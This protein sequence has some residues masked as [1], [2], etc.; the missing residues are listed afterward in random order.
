MSPGCASGRDLPALRARRLRGLRPLRHPVR[1]RRSASEARSE[2]LLGRLAD[3]ALRRC[4]QPHQV[5]DPRPVDAGAGRVE[6]DVAVAVLGEQDRVSESARGAHRADVGV[7]NSVVGGSG[8]ALLIGATA[9]PSSGLAVAC[10]ALAAGALTLAQLAHE[11]RTFTR[12]FEGLDVAFPS[13]NDPPAELEQRPRRLIIQTRYRLPYTFLPCKR[14]RPAGGG[15]SLRRQGPLP[16][17]TAPPAS[18]CPSASP[19]RRGGRGEASH[20]RPV[21]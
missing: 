10:G 21:I 18:G 3:G 14:A 16:P 1:V 11:R 15:P 20:P 19:G 13:P 4:F 7:V 9:D 17:S 12:A 6:A 2:G 5:G 8:V